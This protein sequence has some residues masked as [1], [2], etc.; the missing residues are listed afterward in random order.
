MSEALD[1]ASLRNILEDV[2][3]CKF[4]EAGAHLRAEVR[5][6]LQIQFRVGGNLFYDAGESNVADAFSKDG[7][8]AFPYASSKARFHTPDSKEETPTELSQRRRH[9]CDTGDTVERTTSVDGRR[10]VGTV[11]RDSLKLFSDPSLGAAAKRAGF[12]ADSKMHKWFANLVLDERFD[13]FICILIGVNAITLGI[14]T[15][16]MARTAS[17][18]IPLLFM[19]AENFFCALF[20][21]E[22]MLKLY[23]FRCRYFTMECWKWNLFDLLVISCQLIEEFIALVGSSFVKHNLTFARLVKLLRLVR[24]IRLARILRNIHELRVLVSCITSSMKSLVWIFLLTFFLIYS[25]GLVLTQLVH[26][27]NLSFES[28]ACV[29]DEERCANHIALVLYYGDLCRSI[30]SLFQAISGGQDWGTLLDPLMI[31]V[32][33]LLGILFC[34]YVMFAVLAMMNVVTGI[35]VDSVLTSAKED[36]NNFLL[37]N[38]KEL[39]GP[40]ENGQIT[41][42]QFLGMLE[43]KHMVEFFKAIDVDTKWASSLF[44]LMDL[45]GSGEVNAEEFLGGCIKLRGPARALDTAVLVRDVRSLVSKF[46]EDKVRPHAWSPRHHQASMSSPPLTKRWQ[47]GEPTI[48][49]PGTLPICDPSILPPGML[50]PILC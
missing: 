14:Q 5:K 29:S 26:D 33:P 40:G 15:D 45:D 28:A 42:E 31:E 1:S 3:T 22:L 13:W 9:R 11:R 34:F 35:F 46:K 25:M 27:H 30:L 4:D 2:L 24:I 18:Q 16:H 8:A 43:N 6:E 10:L 12:G 20:T 19:R 37:N 17:E 38:A 21:I 50:P 39:F 23:V 44:H 7:G 47:A 48:L 49:P 36:Q 32:S 41:L